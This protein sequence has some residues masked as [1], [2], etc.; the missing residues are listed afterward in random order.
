MEG[1]CAGVGFG[2]SELVTFTVSDQP[3]CIVERSP[4][5]VSICGFFSLG[6]TVSP[7][8][9]PRF[10][11]WVERLGSICLT[12]CLLGARLG[13]G[14][15][16]VTQSPRMWPRET[17]ALPTGGRRGDPRLHEWERG[18][19]VY[20][21]GILITSNPTFWSSSWSPFLSLTKFCGMNELVCCMWTSGLEARLWAFSG[22]WR[23]LRLVQ[24]L[25]SFWDL[26]GFSFALPSLFLF[27]L[28][29]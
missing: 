24:Q 16:M 8:R 26:V 7:M 17:H 9:S 18:M 13:K 4:P 15:G 14:L 10:P 28:W 2:G 19:T 21:T 3:R 22:L 23:L 25:S 11:C 5:S 27:V 20:F 29:V 6:W 12:T 1:V